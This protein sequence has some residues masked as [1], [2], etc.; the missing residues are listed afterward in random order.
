MQRKFNE[1]ESQESFQ[2]TSD[3]QLSEFLTSSENKMNAGVT[4]YTSPPP[5]KQSKVDVYNKQNII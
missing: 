1:F 3:C 2:L 4:N 5:K